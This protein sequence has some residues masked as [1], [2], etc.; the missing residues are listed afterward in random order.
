MHNSSGIPPGAPTPYLF[1]S[2]YALSP[3]FP[4][5]PPTQPSELFWQLR[6]LVDQHFK[7]KNPDLSI[8][9]VENIFNRI[10]NVVETNK[11]SIL[12]PKD[13]RMIIKSNLHLMQDLKRK[14]QMQAWVQWSKVQDRPTR[15]PMWSPSGARATRKRPR[16][17]DSTPQPSAKC[18]EISFSNILKTTPNSGLGITQQSNTNSAEIKQQ[19]NTCSEII[20]ALRRLA[21]KAEETANQNRPSILR[22]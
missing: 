2:D 17:D 7:G 22:K 12:C 1:S 18:L 20:T 5:P 3:Y 14:R 10:I 11:S 16:N 8:R 13:V 9:D 15:H 6:E 19:L 21:K 4:H